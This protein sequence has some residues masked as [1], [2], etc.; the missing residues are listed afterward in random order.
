MQADHNPLLVPLLLQE[1]LDIQRERDDE[2]IHFENALRARRQAVRGR[3]ADNNLPSIERLLWLANDGRSRRWDDMELDIQPVF[4]DL[5]HLCAAILADAAQ[6]EPGDEDDL[7]PVNHRQFGDANHRA[8][9]PGGIRPTGHV[10][11]ARQPY[12]ISAAVRETNWFAKS[13]EF[14]DDDFQAI[15]RLV[16]SFPNW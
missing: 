10:P 15:Y 4:N 3:R 13:L 2:P 16:K 5:E 12:T 14:D 6:P 9:A 1:L 7:E 11:R 8:P